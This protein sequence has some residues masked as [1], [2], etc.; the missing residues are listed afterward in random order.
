MVR[1][2]TEYFLRPPSEGVDHDS[3]ND[4]EAIDPAAKQ[5]TFPELDAKIRASINE[6]GAVFPKLNFTSPKARPV[7]DLSLS[8]KIINI[9][10]TQKI[11]N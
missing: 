6:Y 8:P 9:K 11:V 10:W 5:Y 4:D 3:D 1:W 2:L 7:E